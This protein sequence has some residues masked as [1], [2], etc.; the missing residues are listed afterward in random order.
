MI[1]QII[2]AIIAF[3]GLAL[4][5]KDLAIRLKELETKLDNKFKDIDEVLVYLLSKD[6]LEQTQQKRKIIGFKS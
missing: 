4:A 1:I 5:N 6:K 3:K 2:R